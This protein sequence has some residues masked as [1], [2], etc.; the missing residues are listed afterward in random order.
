MAGE[1]WSLYST[2]AGGIDR[3]MLGVRGAKPGPT[4]S[5][6]ARLV[7]LNDIEAPAIEPGDVLVAQFGYGL[8]PVVVDGVRNGIAGEGDR[9]FEVPVVDA[10]IIDTMF[11]RM[12]MPAGQQLA[13]APE[14]LCRVCEA[15]T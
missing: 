12:G 9:Q 11:C 10:R 15:R 2:P 3:R 14:E 8:G 4:M 7:E 6:G 13:F 5:G 1:H